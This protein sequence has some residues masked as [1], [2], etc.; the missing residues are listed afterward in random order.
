MCGHYNVSVHVG[1]EIDLHHVPRL[2]RGVLTEGWDG[3]K[4]E[5]SKREGDGEREEE[6]DRRD[7]KVENQKAKKK[8]ETT[9]L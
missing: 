3:R 9:V 5:E 6:G 1:P 7:R 8:G 2:Q 4:C